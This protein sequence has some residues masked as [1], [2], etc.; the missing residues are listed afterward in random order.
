MYAFGAFF[1]IAH[2]SLIAL[3]VKTPGGDCGAPG[4]TSVR[5][6]SWLPFAVL[7]GLATGIVARVVVQTRDAVR[8]LRGWG[9]ALSSIRFIEGICTSGSR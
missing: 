4:R 9:P 1:T 6:V 7:G 2:A 3:R 5:G 8:G